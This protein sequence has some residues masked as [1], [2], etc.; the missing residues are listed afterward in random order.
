[1]KQLI[2]KILREH[3]DSVFNPLEIKFFKFLNGKHIN[4]KPELEK[5]I[6]ETLKLFG[7]S[8]ME[9]THYYELYVHN[10]R[11]DGKYELIT[12]EN[13]NDTYKNKSVKSINQKA[14]ELV[15]AKIPFNASNVS[16]RWEIS[17]DNIPYYVVYS[18]EW[19]PIFCFKN[20]Q[21][22]KVN[23]GWS[24]TTKKQMRQIDP[25]KFDSNSENKIISISPSEMKLLTY[26]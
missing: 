19:Y 15:R 1:M 11:S 22:Y 12:P 8:E 21:W 16:G 9:T 5:L 20:K 17:K 25:F 26:V 4:S 10:Y 18:Y 7:I 24:N 3:V 23:N 6:R 2:R 14:G 13:I